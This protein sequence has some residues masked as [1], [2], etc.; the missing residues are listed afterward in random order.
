MIYKFIAVHNRLP[1]YFVISQGT[2]SCQH[3]R[4]IIQHSSVLAGEE[5]VAKL[6]CLSLSEGER[7]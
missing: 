6:R 2:S 1:T 4:K 5:I 7:E 3:I